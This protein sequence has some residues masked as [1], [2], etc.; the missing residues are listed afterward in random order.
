M[1]RLRCSGIFALGSIERGPGQDKY[2]HR[3]CNHDWLTHPLSIEFVK[4]LALY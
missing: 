3:W 2:F 4:D 1:H